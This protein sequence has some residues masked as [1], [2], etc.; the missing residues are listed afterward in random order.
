MED[1]L[2]PVIQPRSLVS[3]FALGFLTWTSGAA[4]PPLRLVCSTCET[5]AGGEVRELVPAGGAS[6]SYAACDVDEVPITP[7]V[8]EAFDHLFDP[9]LAVVDRTQ[10]VLL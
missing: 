2:R 8:G 5:G 3:L 1:A 7:A 4:Q 9:L 6:A 10:R